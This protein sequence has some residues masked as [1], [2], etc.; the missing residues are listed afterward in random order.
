MAY[1][2]LN[3]FKQINDNYGHQAGDQALVQF[4]SLL[5]SSFSRVRCDCPS[6]W[7]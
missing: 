5:K 7:G 4:A 6:G 1:F 2:D 3:D